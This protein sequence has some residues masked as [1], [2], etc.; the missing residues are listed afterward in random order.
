MVDKDITYGHG[1]QLHANNLNDPNVNI[2]SLNIELNSQTFTISGFWESLN[3]KIL[4]TAF[5]FVK[6]R[7]DTS[8]RWRPPA[9]NKPILWNTGEIMAMRY[10][11]SITKADETTNVLFMFTLNRM[12]IYDVIEHDLSSFTYDY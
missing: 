11:C 9:L 5:K 3:Q 12:V 2:R 7:L 6:S 1:F 8:K 10:T 4:N